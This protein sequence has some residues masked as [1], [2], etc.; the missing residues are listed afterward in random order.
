MGAPEPH[1]SGW[2]TPFLM[3]GC[4][5]LAVVVVMLVRSTGRLRAE[6]AALAAELASAQDKL[7]Q[8]LTKDALA[9]G[10][11]LP[12][13]TLLGIDGTRA[14]RR[15]DSGHRSTA[16][17][18]ASLACD[19]CEAT[20]AHWATIIDEL[21][22]SWD[23]IVVYLDGP[24]SPNDPL[25]FLPADRF[26]A[27]EARVTALRRIPLVPTTMLVGPDGIVDRVWFGP[28][29]EEAAHEV[30]MATAGG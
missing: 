20:G 17:F 11:P 14:E 28:L 22:E 19:A 4:L 12:P 27:P 6:N 24:P 3:V 5:A 15:F 2:F 25:A 18:V 16:V 13:L 1:R 7:K 8:I 10:E 26:G 30:I 9:P 21:P 29:T 23:A